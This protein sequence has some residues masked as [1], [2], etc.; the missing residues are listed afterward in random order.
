LAV[1]IYGS[2][3]QKNTKFALVETS[4]KLRHQFNTKVVV[5]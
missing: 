1:L 5:K 3:H 2:Y 4:R